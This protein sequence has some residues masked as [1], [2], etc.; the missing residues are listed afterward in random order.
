MSPGSDAALALG[1]ARWLIHNGQYDA[2]FVR[3]WSNAPLLVCDDT[4]RLL[5]EHDLDPAA[6]TNHPLAWDLQTSAVLPVRSKSF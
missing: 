2:D 4:G 3:R 1:L 6:P 5:T